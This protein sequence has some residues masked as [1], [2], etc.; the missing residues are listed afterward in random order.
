MHPKR[1]NKIKSEDVIAIYP[2]YT[3]LI[4]FL[5]EVIILIGFKI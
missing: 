4:S 3:H 1:L 2:I 5:A